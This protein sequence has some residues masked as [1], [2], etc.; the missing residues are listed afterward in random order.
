MAL[1]EL[2]YLV[3]VA[4]LVDTERKNVDTVCV[5]GSTIKFSD[6]HTIRLPETSEAI[7]IA[8]EESWPA[9]EHNG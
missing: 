4:V 8:E 2:I 1:V 3:Q 9:W 7:R 6:E 5:E